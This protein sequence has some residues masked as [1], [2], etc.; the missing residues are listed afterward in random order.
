MLAAR[1]T[2]VRTRPSG[3]GAAAQPSYFSRLRAAVGGLTEGERP[4][5]FSQ[6]LLEP[7]ADV[8][9]PTTE[10]AASN[11]QEASSSNTRSRWRWL[12]LPAALSLIPRAAAR[13]SSSRSDD[14]FD[15]LDCEDPRDD[16]CPVCYGPLHAPERPALKLACGHEFCEECVRGVARNSNLC[17]L[18]RRTLHSCTSSQPDSCPLCVASVPL[19]GG[20]AHAPSSVGRVEESGTAAQSTSGPTDAASAAARPGTGSSATQTQQRGEIEVAPIMICLVIIAMT[21]FIFYMIF[22]GKTDH[23]AGSGTY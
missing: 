21:V 16:E 8:L 23:E 11:E 3:A 2:P 5:A 13:S 17:P 6:E 9:A 15:K 20:V 19:A 18:C 1:V 10:D 12:E 7:L 14:A 22:S 4:A